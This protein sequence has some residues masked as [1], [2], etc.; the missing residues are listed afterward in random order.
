MLMKPP[1]Y[2][3]EKGSIDY[4]YWFYGSMAMFQ[5]GGKHW[6]KWR[7][8]VLEA[9]L[10]HQREDGCEKGSWDPLGAWGEEG[11]RVYTTALAVL[12]LESAYR[13]TR[14]IR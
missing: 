4:Y 9:L 12:A 8:A 13:Y 1:A 6:K 11:G 7:E 3:V 10:S 2:D 14:L 5:I